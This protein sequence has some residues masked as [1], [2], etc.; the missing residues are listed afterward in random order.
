MTQPPLRVG[1]IGAGAIGAVLAEAAA[2]SGASVVVCTRTPIDE[3]TVE[4]SGS[5]PV[6]LPVR[7][8]SDPSAVDRP[9]D[10][11]LLTVKATDTAGAAGWLAAM[12][13][14]ST[15]VV[16]VQNGLDHAGRLS[17]YVPA[18]TAVVPGLAYMAAERL[19]AGRVRHLA[20]GLLVVPESVASL[21]TSVL[22]PSSDPPSLT[23]RGAADMLTAAWQKLLGN[24]V[25]NP[26]TALTLRRIDVM[27]E[28]GIAGLARGVVAEAVLVG[29]A[30]GAC[31]S[32]DDVEKVV[33]GTARYGATTG[34]SML[35]DRLAGRPLE[36]QYLTGEV[37]RRGEA[38]GIPVPLNSALLALLDAL[39]RGVQGAP[40]APA[41]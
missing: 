30:S 14:P 20:G 37:V 40:S 2:S 18:A 3:L 39:N 31:L 41:P 34:S 22:G 5:A 35:Y 36:H 32:G 17:P 9:A 33:A 24:L 4:R 10:V 7:L 29:R 21:L 23:V 15:L 19:A 16:A 1:V 11:V 38:F 13:S 8:I 26:I 12:C 6:A 25:A 27:G 28:P